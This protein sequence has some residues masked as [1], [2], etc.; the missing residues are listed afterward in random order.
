M[1][2]LINIIKNQ[3]VTTNWT[4]LVN[5]KHVNQKSITHKSTY[6]REILF[7]LSGEDYSLMQ[8]I[9]DIS[10]KNSLSYSRVS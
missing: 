5:Q 8:L 7:I 6:K 4:S 10:F 9:Y 1:Q 3:H 2:I